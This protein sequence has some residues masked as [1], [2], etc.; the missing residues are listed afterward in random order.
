M[1]IHPSVQARCNLEITNLEGINSLRES[2]RAQ[3][4]KGKDMERV[5]LVKSKT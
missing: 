4:R 2:V 5:V 1:C 3:V